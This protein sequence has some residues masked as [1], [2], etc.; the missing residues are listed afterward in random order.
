VRSLRPRAPARNKN[1]FEK[2][3]SKQTAYFVRVVTKDKRTGKNGPEFLIGWRD[4]P[5]LFDYFVLS[6]FLC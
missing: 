5:L 2:S 4:F 3:S 1:P 6:Y